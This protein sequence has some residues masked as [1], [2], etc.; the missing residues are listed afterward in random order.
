MKILIKMVFFKYNDCVENYTEEILISMNK[1]G[2]SFK[3]FFSLISWISESYF[4]TYFS[5]IYFHIFLRLR[6][7]MLNIAENVC[8]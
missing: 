6:L 4:S 3:C 1:D 2:M 5:F 7:Q 8:F